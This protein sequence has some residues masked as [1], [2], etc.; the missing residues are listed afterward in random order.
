MISDKLPEKFAY[1]SQPLP[2]SSVIDIVGEFITLKSFPEPKT[3]I[4]STCP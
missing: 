1:A 4:L 2:E 3:S